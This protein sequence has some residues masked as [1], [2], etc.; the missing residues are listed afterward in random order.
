M[1]N[2]MHEQTDKP[3]NEVLPGTRRTRQALFQKS[4]IDVSQRHGKA[5][6]I[7]QSLLM[8]S[9]NSTREIRFRQDEFASDTRNPFR[10]CGL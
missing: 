8:Q 10:D 6:A 2:H 7:E 9:L 5:L 4:T 3:I 1:A